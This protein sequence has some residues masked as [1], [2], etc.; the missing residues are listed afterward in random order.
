MFL[1]H[2]KTA[3]RWAVQGWC[4]ESKVLG[5][6]ASPASAPLPG[7]CLSLSRAPDGGDGAP[8]ATQM[9]LSAGR[10]WAEGKG[11]HLPARQTVPLEP[12]PESQ[13][14]LLATFGADGV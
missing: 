14:T 12:F 8:A 9:F 13:V 2:V 1:F 3:W 11:L 6:T 4:P 5:D 10:R 7:V